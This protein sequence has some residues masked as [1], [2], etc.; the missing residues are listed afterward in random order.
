M[1]LLPTWHSV[2]LLGGSGVFSRAAV[3]GSPP[4]FPGQLPLLIQKPL[5]LRAFLSILRNF[6]PLRDY[7]LFF[8]YFFFY[9]ST[10]NF[11]AS[12]PVFI[13]FLTLSFVF[14]LNF[15]GEILA[16]PCGA[17]FFPSLRG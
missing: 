6:T 3:M 1:C 14:L 7:F 13:S 5:L 2:K 12:S 10:Q 16:H 17:I 8:S 15:S 4:T 9:E 11:P